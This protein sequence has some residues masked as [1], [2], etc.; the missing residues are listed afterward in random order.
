MF[1]DAGDHG[2]LRKGELLALEWSDI[3]FDKDEIT[4]SKAMSVVEGK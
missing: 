3:D 2:G 4:V 1:D